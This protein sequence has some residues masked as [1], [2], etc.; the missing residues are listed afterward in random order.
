MVVERFLMLSW[1]S[2]SRPFSGSLSSIVSGGRD[3][4]LGWFFRWDEGFDKDGAVKVDG[5]VYESSD[6][7][8]EAS[9]PVSGHGDGV[10]AAGAVYSAE[11]SE[12][13]VG[14]WFMVSVFVFGRRKFGIHGF[15]GFGGWHFP[16]A[17]LA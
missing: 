17:G 7:D 12:G 8:G 16:V 11:F 2:S 3:F 6:G 1:S 5:D 10:G 4:R 15:R 14:A 13:V 9:C